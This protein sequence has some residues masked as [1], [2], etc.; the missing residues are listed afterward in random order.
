MFSLFA[1]DS[2]KLSNV[3]PSPTL[4]RAFPSL[5]TPFKTSNVKKI[6]NKNSKTQN[7]KNSKNTCKNS[8]KKTAN[9]FPPK[10]Q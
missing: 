1:A 5:Y 9:K 4:E 6:A 2:A 10:K 7:K 8:N 3:I